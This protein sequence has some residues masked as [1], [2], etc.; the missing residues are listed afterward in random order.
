MQCKDSREQF[1]DDDDDENRRTKTSY[2]HTHTPIKPEEYQKN[3]TETIKKREPHTKNKTPARESGEA[4]DR[5]GI[6]LLASR[7]VP[8]APER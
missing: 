3:E 1:D 6:T 4:R 7:F 5:G 2:T 8:I